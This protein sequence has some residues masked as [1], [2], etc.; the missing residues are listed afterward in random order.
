MIQGR[1]FNS[2]QCK[3]DSRYPFINMDTKTYRV[4]LQS[5]PEG[6]YTVMVPALPGCVTYGHNVNHA[7]E[8]AREAIEGYIELLQAQNEPVPDDSQTLEYALT[9]AA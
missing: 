1:F 6:G 3:S 4:L 5:E 8:M 9:I 7:F 2:V